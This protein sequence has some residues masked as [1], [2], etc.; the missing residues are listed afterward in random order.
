MINFHGKQN[1]ARYGGLVRS[2]SRP[3]LPRRHFSPH[4]LQC[5]LG[6]FYPAIRHLWVETIHYR[7]T[8]QLRCKR[9]SPRPLS[10]P[11]SSALP[12]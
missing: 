12:H 3:R 7:L 11:S 1:E 8:T 6:E 4:S 9:A 2:G 5:K 10:P